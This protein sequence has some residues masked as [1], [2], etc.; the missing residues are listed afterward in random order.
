MAE[1]VG[2]PF[3]R[4]L[5]G[6][7]VVVGDGTVVLVG[8]NQTVVDGGEGGGGVRS[9]HFRL[10]GKGGRLSGRG[11]AQVLG[12]PHA[13]LART[14]MAPGV[15]GDEA[16]F[17]I[18]G[19]QAAVAVEVEC[20]RVGAQHF[21]WRVG[22][23]DVRHAELRRLV[24]Q[25]AHDVEFVVHPFRTIHDGTALDAHTTF[26]GL[27]LAV[28][29]HRAGLHVEVD[30]HHV[31]LAPVAVDGQVTVFGQPTVALLAV[32]RH[33]V[34]QP[35]VVGVFI[36]VAGRHLAAHPSRDAN[37]QRE[38]PRFVLCDGECDV[39]VPRI[40]GGLFQSHLAPFDVEFAL[41][42][43]EEVDIDVAVFHGI[44]IAGE[45]GDEAADVARAAGAA[46][47]CLALVLAHRL[48]RVGVEEAVAL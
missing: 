32:D 8:G 6:P 44:H 33:L 5:L 41:V 35:F 2:Q 48:Q 4:T 27:H 18:L 31:A 11:G 45:G 21:Y 40:L 38:L 42:G 7:P 29:P 43:K 9:L 3:R 47:P 23:G 10:R 12:M 19:G 15:V 14:A 1:L 28:G 20:L 37:F 36:E 25:S 30:A 22:D 39:A 24:E 34:G 26:V 17:H 46:K 13:H 16:Q